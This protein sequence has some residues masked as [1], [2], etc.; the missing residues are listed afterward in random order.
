M[1]NFMSL[2]VFAVL[3]LICWT[4]KA[5]KIEKFDEFERD[6]EAE[7]IFLWSP[8]DTSDKK[9]E[10]LINAAE[11]VKNYRLYLIDFFAERV[12]EL[13]VIGEPDL[14]DGEKIKELNNLIFEC[15]R[16]DKNIRTELKI[17]YH[18][19]LKTKKENNANEKLAE[20]HKIN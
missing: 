17:R 3:F 14:Y 4:V 7:W 10:E 15:S 13:L 16:M 8:K 19:L 2:M 20:K 6:N 5:E 12:A 9:T 1:K 11:K 18:V